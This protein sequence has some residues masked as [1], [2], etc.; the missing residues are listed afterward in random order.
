MLGLRA[1]QLTN[2][3][4]LA[5]VHNDC[6]FDRYSYSVRVTFT[7]RNALAERYYIPANRNNVRARHNVLLL[8]LLLQLSAQCEF[9][10]EIFFLPPP[11]PTP[12]VDRSQRAS[13]K[14][15]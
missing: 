3:L 10:E 12:F 6:G 9:R 4:T 15:R 1:A 11:T 5:Y 14:S 2:K 7:V 8:L 13:R